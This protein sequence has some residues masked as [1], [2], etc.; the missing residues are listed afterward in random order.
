MELLLIVP[1]FMIAC[2]IRAE[3]NDNEQINGKDLAMELDT[4][5]FTYAPPATQ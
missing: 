3:V 4:P 1:F 2:N 5:R